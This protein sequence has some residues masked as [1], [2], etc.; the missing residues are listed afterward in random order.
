MKTV[1]LFLRAMSF[2]ISTEIGLFS[3]VKLENLDSMAA[4]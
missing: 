2:M 4:T 1:N 3:A